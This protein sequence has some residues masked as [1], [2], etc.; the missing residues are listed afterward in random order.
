MGAMPIHVLPPEVAAKIAA[1]E[2][3]ERP[4]SVVKELVENAL[5][6]G[7]T[8]IEIEVQG[9][10]IALLRVVDNGCGIPAEDAETAL[11]R[12]ATSKISSDGDLE[13]IGSLGFRGEAL[14]SI[15]AVSEMTLLTRPSAEIGGT[16]VR[17]EHGRVVEKAPKGAPTGTSVT[18]KRLFRNVPAR[19][20]FLRSNS[21]EAGRVT[22][23][24]G[25]YALAYPEVRFSVTIDGRHAFTSEGSGD[26]RGAVAK[27]YGLEAAEAMLEVRRA[28]RMGE[29]TV[30][31]TGL[32]GP[33][34]LTRASRSYIHL[35]VNRRPVQSRAL[36]FAVLDAY[37]GLLMNGRYPMAV[38]DLTIDPAET[39]VNV[40]PAKAEIKF[41]D[42]GIVFSA[43]HREIQEALAQVPLARPLRQGFGA[44]SDAEAP[45]SFT[46]LGSD[47]SRVAMPEA[48]PA[49]SPAFAATPSE[50]PVQ[51]QLSVPALRVLGQLQ[52]TYIVSEG[53]DGMY[54]I[55]QHTAHERVLFDQMRRDKSKSEVRAQGLLEPATIELTPQQEVLLLS[56][57]ELLRDY[58]F[59]IEPFGPRTALLR[60]VPAPLVSGSPGKSLLDLLDRLEGEDLKGYDWED[61]ILATV[62]CHSA[63]RAGHD[64]DPKEM[65]EMVRLLESAD[66]PQT[67]PHGRPIMVHMSSFQLQKEFGRR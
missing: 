37:Q 27:V 47:L 41:R 8:R 29:V 51:A 40:H 53:P 4:S 24:V 33:P 10:G 1:G 62:A 19:L 46:A 28:E 5:D 57:I 14:A 42:E 65:Q 6:A 58:G 17:A 54:L 31:V 9:G 13:R 52:S 16:F 49:P 67:C 38:L 30:K 32:C 50:P 25:H 21:A 44:P 39:D 20:K 63:V 3:V 61:R 34:S 35:F 23:L 64:L 56:Q 66:N 59:D 60:A 7:A 11:L 26:L 55:D 36:A 12:Y 48:V 18:T 15:A 2:V 45:S 22:T 43:V